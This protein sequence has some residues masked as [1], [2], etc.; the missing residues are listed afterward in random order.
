MLESTSQSI[1]E[2]EVILLNFME[3]YFSL[4]LISM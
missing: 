4:E 2:I 3:T 1:D